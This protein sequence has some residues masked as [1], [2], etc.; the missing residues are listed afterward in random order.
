MLRRILNS[1]LIILTVALGR[2][3]LAFQDEA[4]STG[5]PPVA[6]PAKT[7]PT[8]LTI[9]D[10]IPDTTVVPIESAEPAYQKPNH[11]RRD[12]PDQGQQFIRSIVLML[13]PQK[14]DD[15]K[16]WGDETR[17]QSGLKVDF[18]D[19]KLET[20]RRWKNVNHGSWL[21]GSGELVEPEKTFSLKAT[22]LPD[23]NDDTQRY[24]VNVSARLRVRG[25]QQQW[26]YG[27]MLWSISAEA[28]ADISLY[29][30][31]DVKS[32]LVTT[33]KG[34]RLRVV[35]NVTHASAKLDGFKLHRI[36]HAKGT[37]V[38]GYGELFEE[39]IQLRLKKEN[40]DLAARINKAIQ[41]KPDRLEIPF[42]IG[43]WFGISPKLDAEPAVIEKR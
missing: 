37:S 35:P 4:Q 43:G 23:P 41:K 34:S 3:S 39:L 12:L 42:D 28:T 6:V 1:V 20:R 30:S 33:D 17:I 11:S 18:E 14:F 8:E 15:E 2:T 7:T 38:Q 24:E 9:P 31:F 16:G 19:G 27:V 26:N 10:T 21:E 13:L 29:A 36:S 32:Q 40:K 22:Q 5:A 25:R